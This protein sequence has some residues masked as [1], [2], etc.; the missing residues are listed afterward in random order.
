MEQQTK[1][2]IISQ[3]LLLVIVAVVISGC[4]GS[5]NETPTKETD[6]NYQTDAEGVA[7]TTAEGLNYSLYLG[8]PSYNVSKDVPNYI[9]Q[10]IIDKYS[11]RD[12]G[13]YTYLANST[14][15]AQVN[16]EIKNTQVKNYLYKLGLDANGADLAY[17]DMY[18]EYEGEKYLDDTQITLIAINT[19][20]TTNSTVIENEHRNFTLDNNFKD[21]FVV[22]MF[23]HYGVNNNGYG[24]GFECFQVVVL[25]KEY[26]P[27][28]MIWDHTS[29]WQSEGGG[30]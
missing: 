1:L 24:Y 8:M 6:R 19:N 30:R 25:D 14:Y 13:D 11:A 15:Y 18:H 16:I 26:V 2:G 23:M 28:L 3:I 17:D 10:Y 4:I 29:A 5:K 20:G 12:Y 22:K 9:D 27:L 21:V 7:L